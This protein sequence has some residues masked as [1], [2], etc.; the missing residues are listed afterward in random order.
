MRVLALDVG[1]R[2]LGVAVSDP[3]GWTAQGLLTLRRTRDERDC[4]AVLDLVRRYEVERVVVGLPRNMDGSEGER[5]RRTRRFAEQLRRR[6]PV[7]VEEWD[8]RLTTVQAER[9]LLDADLSRAKRKRVVD[10][11]AATLILQSYLERHRRAGDG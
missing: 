10:A 6:L 2:T 8:E 9:A 1:E 4:D 5:A 7:P 11:V 3:L